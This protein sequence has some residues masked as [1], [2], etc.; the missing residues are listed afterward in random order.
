M[1]YAIS[2]GGFSRLVKVCPHQGQEVFVTDASIML[3]KACRRAKKFFK[4]SDVSSRISF[5][6]CIVQ[7]FTYSTYFHIEMSSNICVDFAHTLFFSSKV[8]EHIAPVFEALHISR[9]SQ[10]SQGFFYS[11]FRERIAVCGSFKY[12]QNFFCRK[13]FCFQLFNYRFK[14][15]HV[16]TSNIFSCFWQLYNYYIISTLHK[17][18]FSKSGKK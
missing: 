11:S 5:F 9:H 4:L 10:L 3:V 8:A 18:T 16:M 7:V 1:A 13:A 14:I 12:P 2:F 6:Q 17:A 15:F